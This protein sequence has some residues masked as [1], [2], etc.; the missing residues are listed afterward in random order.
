MEIF[1]NEK[2]VPELAREL[3]ESAVK[4]Q[5]IKYRALETLRDCAE[6]KAVF[7]DWDA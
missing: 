3:S 1:L 4:L 7:Q 6:M 5:M 2:T